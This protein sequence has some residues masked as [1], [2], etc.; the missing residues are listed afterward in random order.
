MTTYIIYQHAGITFALLFSFVLYIYIQKYRNVG[1]N[2]RHDVI[3][4]NIIYIC[5]Y[6][7][8]VGVWEQTRHGDYRN[9]HA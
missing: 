8:I 5:M 1:K 6:M 3:T 7:N 9:M 4:R 2:Y